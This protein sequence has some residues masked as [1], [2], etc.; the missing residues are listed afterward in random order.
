LK[1]AA[2]AIAIAIA[3]SPAGAAPSV[4]R[5]PTERRW[6][7]Y[8]GGGL[9]LA[10]PAFSASSTFA[11]FAEEGSIATRNVPRE[12]PQLEAGVWRAMSR[13][14]GVALTVARSRR[15]APGTFSAAFPHP[16]Y[17]DRHRMAGGALPAGAQRETAVHFGLVWSETRAGITARLTGGPSYML[18][19]ADLVEQVAHTDEYPFDAV[20]V[21]GVRTSPVRGDALGGHAGF[22][23]ERRLAG[24]LA[25]SAGARWA[26]ANIPLARSAVPAEGVRASSARLQA[27]GV[28]AAASLRLSF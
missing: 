21:T 27:G 13:R 7:I 3:A 6:A 1:T 10:A 25:L 28:T 22:T 23:L 2:A 17:L 14:L 15:D 5:P 19:E 26:R 8:A 24:R 4:T 11:E 9:A 18:A 12:G 16:L 20:Q